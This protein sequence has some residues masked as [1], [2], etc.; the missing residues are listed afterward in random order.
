MSGTQCPSSPLAERS[1]TATRLRGVRACDECRARRVRCI[2]SNTETCLRCQQKASSCVFSLSVRQYRVQQNIQRQMK[3]RPA[4]EPSISTGRVESAI[5]TVAEDPKSATT[6]STSPI[7]Q[8]GNYLY[9]SQ[10]LLTSCSVLKCDKVTVRQH[11]DAFFEFIHPIPGYSFLHRADILRLYSLGSL[12]SV[13]L[14][15]I[16]GAAARFV[17]LSH[18]TITRAKSWINAAESKVLKGLGETRPYHGEALMILGFNRRCNHQSGKAFFFVSLAARMVYHLKLHRE[19]YDLPFMEQERRRR[20][21]WCIFTVDRFC[22]GGIQVRYR[23]PPGKRYELGL[24]IHKEY[25][26]LPTASLQVQLPCTD[27]YFE[28]DIAVK[29]CSLISK[30]PSASELSLFALMLRLFDIR[31]RVLQ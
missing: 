9:T 27:R 15:A 3:T 28:N 22:A 8:W 17:P 26:V 31:N 20:L 16:C 18:I 25:I 11:I 4:D 1:P 14:L 23:M 7:D 5:T 21:V 10:T 2:H 13:I 30:Q 12:P 19:N 24:T 6:D 29:T